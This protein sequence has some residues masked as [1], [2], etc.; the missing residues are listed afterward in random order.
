MGK[1][2]RDVHSTVIK[3]ILFGNPFALGSYFDEI[4]LSLN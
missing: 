4:S 2:S 1:K 3:L